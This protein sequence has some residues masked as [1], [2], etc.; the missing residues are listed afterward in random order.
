[1]LDAIEG[2]V[3]SRLQDAE[4]VKHLKIS[5]PDYR[6]PEQTSNPGISMLSLPEMSMM[7]FQNFQT[8][9]EEAGRE[10]LTTTITERQDKF[11]GKYKD[12]ALTRVKI[13]SEDIKSLH[14]AFSAAVRF[15]EEPDGWL[16]FLGQSFCGKTHLAAAAGNYQIALGGQAMLV[17]VSA[18][19]D[20]LRQTFNSNSDVAFERR[21][22][23]VRAAPLLILDD[24]KESSASSAWAE[25][26]L[27]SLLNYRYNAHLPTVLT[28]ALSEESLALSYPSLWNKLSDPS[29]RQ[30]LSINMPSYRRAQKNNKAGQY[31]V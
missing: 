27:Y 22:H 10:S 3:R 5:A 6:R 19:F 9:E 2:R 29:R 8:R 20:Y 30:I 13:T 24:L 26:K 12:K 1:M 17:D 18:L 31:R 15:S 21:F 4:L 25:D 28:S 14:V 23:E 7:T 16:V 11:G